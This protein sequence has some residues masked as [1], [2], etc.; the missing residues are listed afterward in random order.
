M[1]LLFEQNKSDIQLMSYLSLDVDN[2][3]S[4]M[5]KHFSSHVLVTEMF[6]LGKKS[7]FSRINSFL[8]EDISGR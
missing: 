8:L 3:L 1:I 5:C 7:L 4:K 6:N 2:I